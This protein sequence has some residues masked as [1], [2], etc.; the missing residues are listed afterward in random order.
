M[1]EL[2]LILRFLKVRYMNVMIDQDWLCAGTAAGSVYCWTFLDRDRI[3]ENYENSGRS[4]VG[5]DIIY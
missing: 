2:Y 4:M 1:M 5:F 3:I